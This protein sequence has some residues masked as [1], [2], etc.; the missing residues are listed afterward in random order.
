MK[1][2][3]KQWKKLG[4]RREND[5]FRRSAST[6]TSPR[7][8]R[9]REKKKDRIYLPFCAVTCVCVCLVSET[10]ILT[11]WYGTSRS[12]KRNQFRRIRPQPCIFSFSFLT[13]FL[14]SH[15]LSI[16]SFFTLF[17]RFNI[18]HQSA[19]SPIASQRTKTA[20]GDETFLRLSFPPNPVQGLFYIFFC[21]GFLLLV[22][23]SLCER[24]GISWTR[25]ERYEG[26]LEFGVLKT[27][28]KHTN[29]CRNRNV[30]RK[31]A[32]SK[33]IH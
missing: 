18:C 12:S 32:K 8:A 6:C 3:K 24:T 9:H 22:P 11:R 27:A 19:V 15:L 1:K 14:S 16:F 31:Y 28:R 5:W 33:A 25:D 17:R 7:F 23:L 30:K 26:N 10:K 13:V 21:W 20:T 2:R 4:R 29:M